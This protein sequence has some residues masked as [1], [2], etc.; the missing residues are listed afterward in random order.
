MASISLYLPLPLHGL[1][2]PML[3]LLVLRVEVLKGT[4]VALG[5]CHPGQVCDWW[6]ACISGSE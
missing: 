3:E 1:N 2:F 4:V 5:V 6:S